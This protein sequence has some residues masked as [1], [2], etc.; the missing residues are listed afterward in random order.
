MTK[1]QC[2]PFLPHL[3]YASPEQMNVDS[4]GPSTAFLHKKGINIEQAANVHIFF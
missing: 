2:P 4:R 3:K 1:S